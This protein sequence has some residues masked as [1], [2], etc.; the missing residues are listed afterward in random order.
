MFCWFFQQCVI[1]LQRPRFF[2]WFFQFYKLAIWL[3]FFMFAPKTTNFIIK[4]QHEHC[5]IFRQK[6]EENVCLPRIILWLPTVQLFATDETLNQI[7]LFLSANCYESRL[8]H[9]ISITHF[10]F[11]KR[12]VLVRLYPVDLP[13]IWSGTW[14]KFTGAKQWV[15]VRGIISLIERSEQINAQSTHSIDSLSITVVVFLWKWWL[16]GLQLKS[17]VTTE[18]LVVFQFVRN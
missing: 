17:N 8:S 11:S 10:V 4:I 2:V 13:E 1:F 15:Q 12:P 7:R 3:M 5:N 14:K 9:L 18:F 16:N 6:Y